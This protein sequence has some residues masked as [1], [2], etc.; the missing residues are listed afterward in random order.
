MSAGEGNPP[1]PSQG[2]AQHRESRW[3]GQGYADITKLREVAAKHERLS[4]RNQQ[5]AA[6]INTR[7]EKIRHAAAVLR[8]KAQAVLARIPDLEQEMV[9]YEKDIKAKTDRTRGI[10]IGSDVTELQFRIRKI[11]QKIVDLQHKS[12]TLEHR[13]ATKTQKTAEL[14]VKVDRYLE[15]GKLEEQE[16]RSYRQRA[17]RL[18]LATQG[19][20]AS[21]LSGTPEPDPS[22]APQDPADPR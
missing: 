4:S 22:G 10:T 21:R 6:R 16:A 17:D 8:E 9:Q 19:E 5:R 18:Q 11:Q 14:K 3:L 13:A 7:I 15:M 12:R 1:T 2:P 20:M